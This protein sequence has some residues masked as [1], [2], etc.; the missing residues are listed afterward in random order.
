MSGHAFDGTPLSG[1]I[2]PEQ[3]AM[4]PE[5]SGNSIN[6]L[7]EATVRQPTPIYWHN[8]RELDWGELQTWMLRKT[9]E[10]VPETRALDHNLGGRGSKVRTP[11]AAEKAEGD[12]DSFTDAAKSFA[13]AHEADQVAVTRMRREWFFEGMEEDLPWIVVMAVRMDHADLAA[14]PE[15][16]SVIEVMRAYNR[17]TRAARALADWIRGQGY[18]AEPHGGPTAG[19]LT[20]IPPALE[21][22]LGELGK[23]GSVINREFGASFRLAGVLTDMPL[24]AD[25]PDSFGVD[26]FCMNCRVCENACPPD[27]IAPA[28]QTVRGVEKWYVDF[29]KCVPFFNQTFGCGICIAVCP[30]SRPEVGPRLLQKMLRRLDSRG[31]EDA[32]AGLT[33]RSGGE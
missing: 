31:S 16:P 4:I 2:D 11:V 22:G 7:G 20:L 26:A 5:R 15:P 27:A 24:L 10:E 14:A 23:H 33:R 8:P 1:E 19:P 17:G 29:D 30:W 28:K 3:L 18:R 6:G 9:S 32:G 21:A 12:P 13:L 25:A